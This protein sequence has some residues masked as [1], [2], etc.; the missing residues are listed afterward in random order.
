MHEQLLHLEKTIL[1]IKKQHRLVSAELNMLKQQSNGSKEFNALK[2]SLENTQ[3][4][5]DSLKKQL[6]AFDDRY[7]NL[8]EAHHMLGEEQDNLQ[9][10][11]SDVQ[12]QNKTLQQQNDELQQ[13]NAALQRQVAEVEKKNSNLQEKNRLASERTQVVL[14]RLTR[15][16][17]VE[18]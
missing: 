11:L 15:I 16:D 1:T 7:Q 13:Q 17:Q 8:A 3:I 18:S 4:E 12:Q 2:T 9:Q 6:S 5:R 14:D 10:Q